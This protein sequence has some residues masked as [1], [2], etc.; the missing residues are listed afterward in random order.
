[1]RTFTDNETAVSPVVG[2]MLMLVVTIIIAAVVSAFSGGL[3]QGTSKAPQ[4]SLGAEV[5][6]ASYI[7]LDFKGGDSVSGGAIT[8]RTFIPMGTF[9]DMSNKVDLANATYLTDNKPVY[10]YDPVTY[11]GRGWATIQTGDKIRINW[12]DAF[13]PGY[14][15]GTYSA[16]AVGE[17]VNIEIYDSASG[18]MIVT[19]QTTVL[20]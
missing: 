15:A 10:D 12:E 4:I 1:M 20:P 8:V 2:V 16:P 5:H 9:K 17:P 3:S 13:V 6:N 14:Y 19:M 18:K 11:S 7:I